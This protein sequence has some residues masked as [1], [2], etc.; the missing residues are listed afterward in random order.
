MVPADPTD[1][2][3]SDGDPPSDDQ[4]PGHRD[5]PSDEQ[6]AATAGSSSDADAATAGESRAATT[7]D[8]ESDL[9]EIIVY[10]LAGGVAGSVLSFVPFAPVLGGG[11]AAYLLDGGTT[12]GMKTGA[13]AGV[14]ASVPFALFLLFFLF[15]LGIVGAPASFGV[16][17]VVVILFSIV[18]TVAFSVLGGYLGVYVRRE[19]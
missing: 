4:P 5:P 15:L 11:I 3:P 19:L 10:G 14:V 18:Y 2:P 9:G 13:V 12:D 1:E 8:Q 6:P 17:V 7:T 16:L